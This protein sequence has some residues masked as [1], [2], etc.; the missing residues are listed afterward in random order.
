[1]FKKQLR[2]FS[3]ILITLT[4]NSYCTFD[5][6]LFYRYDVNFKPYKIANEEFMVAIQYEH[7]FDIHSRNVCGEKRNILQIWN[8]DIDSLAMLRGF[9]QKTKI[10]SLAADLNAVNDVDARGHVRPCG[11]LSADGY[12]T[13]LRYYLPHDVFLSLFIPFY[14][15]SLQNISFTDLTEDNSFLDDL[16]KKKLTN[17]FKKNV[18]KLGCLNLSDWKRSAFGDLMFTAEWDKNFVQEKPILNEVH[19]NGRLGANIPTGSKRNEDRLFSI[20]FGHNF[21][22]LYF[23]GGIDL[24]W[25]HILKGGIDIEFLNLFAREKDVRI[26]TDANQTDLLYLAKT[27]AIVDPGFISRYNLYVEAHKFSK[28]FSLRIAYQ[29]YRR[30]RERVWLFNNDFSNEVANNS[31]SLRDN[32]LHQFLF[33]LSRSF[34]EN[35]LKPNISFYYKLPFNGKKTIQAQ[36]IGL[37]FYINF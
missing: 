22:G 10:G 21:W 23:G 18:K 1:M 16:T 12:Y 6:N 20:P 3:L 11:H 25:W 15:M 28:D 5:F 8:D 27:R 2:I 14:T 19:L 24:L 36:T 29:Y 13:Y 33:I 30:T 31:E 35:E 7:G 37:N 32:T 4:L 17:D 34:E 26:R 9:D